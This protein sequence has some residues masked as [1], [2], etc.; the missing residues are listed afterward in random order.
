MTY[1]E[2]CIS[3]WPAVGARWRT[4]PNRSQTPT[5]RPHPGGAGSVWSHPSS[6]TSPPT[7]FPAHIHNRCRQ[8]AARPRP[9]D[10]VVR[11][12]FGRPGCGE[13]AIVH[14]QNVFDRDQCFNPYHT[15]SVRYDLPR[16]HQ[17]YRSNQ[18]YH[19][20]ETQTHHQ[21]GGGCENP[22]PNP[23]ADMKIGAENIDVT[24]VT[25]ITGTKQHAL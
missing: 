1:F 8:A 23:A 25:L 7:V 16:L 3:I 12:D 22:A 9:H 5:P 14:C 20:C 13:A 21:R 24:S 19:R 2:E 17:N 6:A 10:V 18:N 11:L 15:Y 4:K